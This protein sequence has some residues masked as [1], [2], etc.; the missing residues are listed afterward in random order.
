MKK[1]FHAWYCGVHLGEF[2]N[3]KDAQTCI[4]T[5]SSYFKSKFT[6]RGRATVGN[7]DHSESFAIYDNEGYG[8][9][10]K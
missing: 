1:K 4:H 2:E 3:I 10:I 6:K 8:W 9:N 7:K 5:H